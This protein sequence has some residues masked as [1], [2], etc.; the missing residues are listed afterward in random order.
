[1]VMPEPLVAR[2]NRFAASWRAG[3]LLGAILLGWTVACLALQ[4]LSPSRDCLV[5]VIAVLY[6]G[7]LTV[8]RRWPLISA[9]AVC[10]VLL[11]IPALGLVTAFAGALGVAFLWLLFL[12]G[13][14]LGTRSGLAP[15]LAV[16]VLLAVSANLAS[17]GFNPLSLVLTLGPWLVGRVVL[18]RRRLNDQLRARNQELAAE[19]ELF[20]LESVRHER[21]VIARDL[22]DIVAHCLSV[23]VVQATAGQRLPQSDA[24]GVTRALE[25]VAEAAEQARGEVGQLVRLLSGKAGGPA[26]RLD[27]VGDLVA[28]A[29]LSG[30]TVTCSV[31]S[32]DGQLGPAASE[33]AYRLVQEALTN[34]VKHAPG[35]PAEVT[36]TPSAG[37]VQVSVV[38]GTPTQPPSGLERSGSGYGLAGLRDRISLCGGTLSYG[39]TPEGGWQVS[40]S[41]PTDRHEVATAGSA[42]SR[43]DGGPE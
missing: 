2:L 16:T 3:A 37:A 23:M 28:R 8:R 40:A 6:A 15:G 35:A 42:L 30:Q 10:A 21:A 29:R 27:Q 11:A 4:P 24:A 7:A 12:F 32:P 39:P 31:E 34:A 14:A 41:F 13:Y 26:P 18:S 19:R 9:L 33:A 5:V 1:M 25:T 38:N 43:E 17:Q 36:I 20:A 22:H